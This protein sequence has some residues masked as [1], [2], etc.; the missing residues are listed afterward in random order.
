MRVVAVDFQ[1]LFLDALLEHFSTLNK[2][3]G[4]LRQRAVGDHYLILSGRP[5]VPSKG[6]SPGPTQNQESH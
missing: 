5:A 6:V 2:S 3:T 4:F 1:R